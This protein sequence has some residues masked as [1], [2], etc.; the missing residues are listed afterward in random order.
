MKQEAFC[1][2]CSTEV[3][4]EMNGRIVDI[5]DV[6][7]L[8]DTCDHYREIQKE[9]NRVEFQKTTVELGK[10]VVEIWD[11][12]GAPENADLWL[13]CVGLTREDVA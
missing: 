10:L 6:M 12:Q 1:Y 8:C 4:I 13:K 11:S 5:E 2:D 9:R 7:I 3:D